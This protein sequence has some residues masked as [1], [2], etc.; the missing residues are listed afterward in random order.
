MLSFRGTAGAGGDG[1][2]KETRDCMWDLLP[3]VNNSRGEAEPGNCP[4]DSPESEEGWQV[5]GPGGPQAHSTT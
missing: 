4:R 3:E 1:R 2:T 5:R